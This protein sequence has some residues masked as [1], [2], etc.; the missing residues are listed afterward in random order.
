M[1]SWQL[2][3]TRNVYAKMCNSNMQSRIRDETQAADF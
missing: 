3:H 2:V 1:A